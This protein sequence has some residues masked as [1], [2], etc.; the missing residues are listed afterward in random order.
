MAIIDFDSNDLQRLAEKF[1][2]AHSCIHGVLEELDQAV[3]AVEPRWEGDARFAFLRFYQ[4][5]RKGVEAH[6]NAL[7]KTTDHLNT[8]VE[9]HQRIEES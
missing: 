9:A 2:Q 5:W 4:D 8:L 6:S 7:K 1:A 3:K